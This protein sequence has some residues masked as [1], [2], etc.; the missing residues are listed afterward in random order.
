MSSCIPLPIPLNHLIWDDSFHFL[1]LLKFQFQPHT[2]DGLLG[3]LGGPTSWSQLASDCHCSHRTSWP[4]IPSPRSPT[5]TEA[6]PCASS[7]TWEYEVQSRRGSRWWSHSGMQL[8][9]SN[10]GFSV[11]VS[12][13]GQ[14][15]LGGHGIKR[16][17]LLGNQPATSYEEAPHTHCPTERWVGWELCP[18]SC[19]CHLSFSDSGRHH[20]GTPPL[21]LSAWVTAEGPKDS[22]NYL[23]SSWE[24]AFIYML[25]FI[26]H[27]HS[28]SGEYYE[29]LRWD[30]SSDTRRDTSSSSRITSVFHLL[31]PLK[32]ILYRKA[33]PEGFLWVSLALLNSFVYLS[34]PSGHPEVQRGRRKRLWLNFLQEH[35]AREWWHTNRGGMYYIKGFLRGELNNKGF[36]VD[37]QG[38]GVFGGFCG[39]RLFVVG[40]HYVSAV[41][42]VSV[43]WS[44][45]YELGLMVF[46][47]DAGAM[48]SPLWA[49]G[50]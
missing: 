43:W 39:S 10:T 2:P 5:R 30:R 37:F 48:P 44:L 3:F 31:I 50:D 40:S 7:Y 8:T 6:T 9:A 41:G 26:H 49:S 28:F 33:R 17:I 25:M 47:G 19:P 46:L 15:S 4:L 16:I 18:R 14:R 27:S 36:R 35:P 1:R 13:D 42:E 29:G 11:L 32:C 23:L 21:T 24:V 34:L 20:S 12:L 38:W 45:R 22:I